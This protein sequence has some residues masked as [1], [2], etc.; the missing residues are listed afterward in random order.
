MGDVTSTVV[1]MFFQLPRDMCEKVIHLL[2]E[3]FLDFSGDNI[4]K[5]NKLLYS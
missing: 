4:R 3:K 2:C 1:S 5:H